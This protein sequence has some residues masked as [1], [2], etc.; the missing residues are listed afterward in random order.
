MITSPPAVRPPSLAS[1]PGSSPAAELDQPT[2]EG[3]V[4]AVI[5]LGAVLVLLMWWADTSPAS[6]HGAGAWLT[7]AGRVTGLVGTYLIVVGVLLMGRVTGLD[8]LIGMD[9]L[10]VWHRRI[11]VAPTPGSSP[12]PA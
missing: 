11:A 8:R 7:A 10:A 2:R 12:T 3:L 5:G 1:F 6:L 9:R 4:G